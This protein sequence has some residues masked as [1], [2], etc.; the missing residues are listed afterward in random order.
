MVDRI[1]HLPSLAAL[2][3]SAVF[4]GAGFW[5]DGGQPRRLFGVILAAALVGFAGVIVATL[6]EHVP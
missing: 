6:F 5:L 3:L 2:G 4:T 1:S